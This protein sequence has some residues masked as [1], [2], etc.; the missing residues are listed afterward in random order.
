M[1]FMIIEKFR[2]NDPIPAY[3]RLKD[4]DR[5]M[6]EGLEYIDSW[7]EANFGRC[8]QLMRCSDATLLQKWLL[9]LRDLGLQMELVPV[10][11]SKEVQKL[12]APYLS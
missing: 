12:V 9:E 1:L 3:Q 7:I 10:V 4:T 2:D 5:S 8:F 11:P 6:P